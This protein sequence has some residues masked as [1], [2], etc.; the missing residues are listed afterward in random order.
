MAKT[1]QEIQ[2]VVA[3]LRQLWLGLSSYRLYPGSVDRPGFTAAVERIAAAATEAL[4]PGPVDVEIR[5]GRCFLEGNPVPADDAAQRLALA[6]FERRVERLTLRAVPS[7][8][9]L[10]KLY[11]ILSTPA[12]QLVVAGGADAVLQQEGV[13]AVSLSTL[14]PPRVEGA[15]HVIDDLPSA[16]PGGEADLV[17]RLPTEEEEEVPSPAE[18]AEAL[19]AQLRSIAAGRRPDVGRGADEGSSGEGPSPELPSSVVEA[20]VDHIRDDPM[21]RRLIGSM[22][23]AELTRTL[24]NLGEVGGGDPVELAEALA[25]AGVRHV[26]VVDLTAALRAG[27]EE[28]G[29]IIAGLEQLGID[30]SS[31]VAGSSPG[32]VTEAL[33][34]YLVATRTDDIRAMRSAIAQSESESRSSAIVALRDY[35]T[36]EVELERV[37]EVLDVWARELNDAVRSADVPR[38]HALLPP[39]RGALAGMS[40]ERSTLFEMYTRQSLDRETM[41]ELFSVDRS[42]GGSPPEE[43][44]LPFGDLGVDVLLDLLAEEQDRDRRARLLG[45]LR[46]VVPSHP[47]TVLKRLKDPRWYVVRNA[48]TLLGVAGGAE[49]LEHLAG[50]AGHTSSEVRRE[51]TAALAAAGGT[52]SVPI[53]R[54]LLDEGPEDTGL[55]VVGALGTLAG[56]EASAALA[57]IVASSR[58][59]AVRELALDR[60]AHRGG[61]RELLLQLGSRRSRPRLAWGLR[62]RARRLAARSGSGER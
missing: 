43:V 10:D 4:L 38:I 15:D 26:D 11:R 23:N 17:P 44:L 28:A 9:D 8:N 45:V 52:A 27:R 12:P 14:G 6:C 37:G 47:R 34:D 39:V 42:A 57:D 31:P 32:S 25:S 40:D 13:V 54:R 50:A 19:L 33:S 49:N 55:A 51:A 59:R 46:R 58:D 5:G 48:V 62:R 41:T 20:L 24:V 1:D 3:L 53:L 30:V 16:R 18:Q 22:N 61:G 35:L 29:T 7:V 2:A 60:L 21:V 56:P 36:L